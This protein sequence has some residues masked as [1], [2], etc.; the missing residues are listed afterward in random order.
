MF[1]RFGCVSA[2][3]LLAA[4]S[5]PARELF[6]LA[7]GFELEARSHVQDHGSYVL[8]TATGTLEIPVEQVVS[9][10]LIADP[11]PARPNPPLSIE[12][13]L[14]AGA[15]SQGTA[16]E[17]IRFVH[18]VA[19]VESALHPDAISPKG[20]I[21]LMQLMPST[22]KQLGVLPSD[23]QAN[24]E[25]GAKYLRDLLIRYKN[26]AV[27][28]LAAYNAGPAAVAKFGGVPPF[29][30]TRRYIERVLREYARETGTSNIPARRQ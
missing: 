25:G 13:L 21:G 22:A 17:F 3:C 10:E 9:I 20:A 24:I 18:S 7:T 26:N 30:E 8:A 23:L 14:A 29:D 16:P 28:A 2:L 12:S 27:L 19:L 1:L 11:E 5:S 15:A 6:H 4:L